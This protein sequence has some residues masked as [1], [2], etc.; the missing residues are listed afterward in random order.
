[1]YRCAFKHDNVFLHKVIKKV[2]FNLMGIV[3]D[4]IKEEMKI[5]GYGSTMRDGWSKFRTH[6]V[7]IHA[8]YNT[9]VSRYIGK[10]ESSCLQPTNVLLVMRPMCGVKV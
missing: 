7:G 1:M 4:T 3:E 10:M 6:F 9:A 5:T 2:L 8:Q